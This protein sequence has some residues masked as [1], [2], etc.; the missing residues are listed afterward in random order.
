MKVQDYS[1]DV[2][3][4]VARSSSAVTS[5]S[6]AAVSPVLSTSPS[7]SR[8]NRPTHI[9]LPA[10]SFNFDFD[11]SMASLDSLNPPTHSGYEGDMEFEER[12]RRESHGSYGSYGGGQVQGVVGMQQT[13]PLQMHFSQF[14]QKGDKERLPIVSVVTWVEASRWRE[15]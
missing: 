8:A 14:L 15:W 7:V 6:S 9:A 1:F 12:T 13:T 5:P 11:P 10:P 3:L 4:R 2:S